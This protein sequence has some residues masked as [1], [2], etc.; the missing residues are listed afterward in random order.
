MRGILT[1]AAAA[2]I[3]EHTASGEEFP[4]RAAIQAIALFVTLGTLLLQGTTVGWLARKLKFDLSAER[5]RTEA[6]RERGRQIAAEAATRPAADVDAGFEAQRLALGK[7]V[8]HRHL[9]EETARELI[10][11]VDLRQAARHTTPSTG[12]V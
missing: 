10:E 7:A 2:S 8:R 12:P 11:D 1:L 6:E 4:G 5:A 3:P 9:S